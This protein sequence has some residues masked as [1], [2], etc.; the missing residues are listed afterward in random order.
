MTP[1]QVGRLLARCALVDKR[2]VD[3][4]EVDVWHAIVGDLAFTA[5]MSAV[6]RY[7]RDNRRPIT[8]ADLRFVAEAMAREHADRIRP[9]PTAHRAPAGGG[10]RGASLTRYVVT[11]LARARRE[12]GGRLG[13]QRAA[14][15]GERLMRE[16]LAIHPS[17]P[18][19][20]APEPARGYPCQRADCPCTHG[21]LPG[22]GL[23]HG[24][25]ITA[26]HAPDVAQACHV[27]HPK[28]AEALRGDRVLAVRRVLTNR[29]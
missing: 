17:P 29:I 2:T 3:P 1:Q 16:A 23:C 20:R 25:W 18:A 28:R 9:D 12:H 7:Y 5:A 6:I 22:L 15:T 13:R 21:Y 26:D 10:T 14:E 24:G 19:T 27:C 8:P 11:G 4:D